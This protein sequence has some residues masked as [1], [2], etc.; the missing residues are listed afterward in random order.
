LGA[1]PPPPLLVFPFFLFSYEMRG[2]SRRAFGGVVS[3]SNWICWCPWRFSTEDNTLVFFE[4]RCFAP[5][6]QHLV[7]Q[8]VQVFSNTGR[9][10][11]AF[12]QKCA[13]VLPSRMAGSIFASSG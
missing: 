10:Q 4:I 12:S 5:D 11:T 9:A 2:L 8:S 3:A 1:P 13:K 6:L 7:L